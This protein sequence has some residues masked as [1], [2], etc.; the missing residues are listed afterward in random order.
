MSPGVRKS[1]LI[2]DD[3]KDILD[4][5]SGFLKRNG[6]GVSVADTGKGGLDLAKK[7]LPGLIILDLM[8]PDIDGTDVAVELMHNPVTREIPIIFLT[9]VMT[10]AEQEQSGQI[11]ANRCIVAKPCKSEEILE[12]VKNRIG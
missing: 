5:L 4:S 11:I 12:L 10:K 8:L 6:Y 1:I 2:V 7:E 3:E 9:S